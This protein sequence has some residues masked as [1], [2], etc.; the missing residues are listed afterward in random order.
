VIDSQ[1][2]DNYSVATGELEAGR[3]SVIVPSLQTKVIK[4][5]PKGYKALKPC[6]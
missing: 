3:G 5:F 1:L 6:G 2:Y 4:Q